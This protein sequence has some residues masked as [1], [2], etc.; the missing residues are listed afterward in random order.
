MYRQLSRVSD[1]SRS[2][3]KKTPLDFPFRDTKGETNTPYIHTHTQTGTPCTDGCVEICGGGDLGLDCHNV[4]IHQVVEVE[5]EDAAIC[6]EKTHSE[7]PIHY[8]LKSMLPLPRS[9]HSSAQ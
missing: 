2:L 8:Q 3:Q 1:L 5:M 9:F 7:E 6:G 4:Q